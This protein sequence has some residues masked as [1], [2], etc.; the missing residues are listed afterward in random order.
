MICPNCNFDNETGSK[1]CGECGDPLE[2]KE[3]AAQQ[4]TTELTS[5]M[6]NKCPICFRDDR[7]RKLSTVYESGVTIT[8]SSGPRIGVGLTSEKKIG[9]GIGLASD[10]GVNISAS[11]ARLSPP[12]EPSKGCLNIIAWGLIIIGG[13]NLLM[14]MAGLGVG[15]TEGGSY[16]LFVG[17]ICSVIGYLIMQNIK[18]VYANNLEKYGYWNKLWNRMYYCERDD[19]VFDP[20]SDIRIKVSQL[21]EF[22]NKDL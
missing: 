10:S 13:M 16:W 12:E 17:G 9:V 6:D 19:I 4:K 7:T 14:A 1:F 15:N 3:M 22:Y 20:T 5:T 11:S 18:K 2:K 8:Q 21:Q